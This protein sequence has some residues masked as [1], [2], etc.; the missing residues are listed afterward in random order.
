MTE[1]GP[2]T[3]IKLIEYIERYGVEGPPPQTPGI[4]YCKLDDGSGSHYYTNC[5]RHPSKV[6]LD[7]E[8]ALVSDARVIA[9][10]AITDFIVQ[11]GLLAGIAAD[12][13][14]QIRDI[15]SAFEQASRLGEQAWQ[16]EAARADTAEL[17][18]ATFKKL[19]ADAEKEIAALGAMLRGG[20][21]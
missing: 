14:K 9:H 16:R 7:S 19:H 13:D 1:V 3:G 8:F 15:V 5:E 10:L 18:L 11:Q 4:Y 21:P 12:H 20:E 6:L 17:Q 2:I